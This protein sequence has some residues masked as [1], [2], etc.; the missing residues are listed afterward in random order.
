M[1]KVRGVIAEPTRPMR[2]MSRTDGPDSASFFPAFL[3]DIEQLG[4]V[5]HLAWLGAGAGFVLGSLG[6][7]PNPARFE[8]FGKEITWPMIRCELELATRSYRSL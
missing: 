8:K 7:D 6:S 5:L 2:D 3:T 4:Q 1:V